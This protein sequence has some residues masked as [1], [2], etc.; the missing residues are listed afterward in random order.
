MNITASNMLTYSWLKFIYTP[1]F[2][3]CVV[4][5][6]QTSSIDVFDPER[7]SSSAMY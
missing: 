2:T 3:M 4:I 6:I 5:C 1:L 7:S